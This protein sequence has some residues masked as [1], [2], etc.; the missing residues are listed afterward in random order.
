MSVRPN[1]NEM[2]HIEREAAVEVLKSDLS[3]RTSLGRI[4]SLHMLTCVNQIVFLLVNHN[5]NKG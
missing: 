1:G 3:L 4:T 2:L 5:D